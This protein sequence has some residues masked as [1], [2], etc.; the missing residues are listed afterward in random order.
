MLSPTIQTDEK[1]ELVGMAIGGMY[2]KKSTCRYV[3]KKYTLTLKYIEIIVNLSS[4]T[5]Q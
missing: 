5:Y 4:S 3:N 1:L 2:I